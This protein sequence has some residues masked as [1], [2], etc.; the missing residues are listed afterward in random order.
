[1]STVIHAHLAHKAVAAQLNNVGVALLESSQH[2]LAAEA[3]A[4]SMRS[5]KRARRAL[6]SPAEDYGAVI[7]E[8]SRAIQDIQTHI[9][10]LQQQQ[11]QSCRAAATY[12]HGG[13][14]DRR[15]LL[16][17]TRPLLLN[18]AN[19]PRSFEAHAGL[20]ADQC[21]ESCAEFLAVTAFNMA[22]THHIDALTNSNSSHNGA[23]S[24]WRRAFS[25]Y[26]MAL[27]LLSKCPPVSL[28]SLRTTLNKAM[29]NNM[30]QILTSQGQAQAARQYFNG[31]S[32]LLEVASME[33]LECPQK[34]NAFQ[35]DGFALNVLKT[36]SC[37]SPAA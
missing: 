9:Q 6:D 19:C 33:Q 34:P 20:T 1:M 23:S 8:T 28:T 22:L 17:Y 10:V 25:S 29:L 3:F 21:R 31:L 14:H 32:A 26:T 36:S 18:G 27:S 5:T 24:S 7:A 12:A 15:G 35:W 2:Q 16:V 11:Q 4:D 13:L 37:P 30:G